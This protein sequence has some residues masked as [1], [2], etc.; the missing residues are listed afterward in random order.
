MRSKSTSTMD[1]KIDK[2]ELH[3]GLEELMLKKQR[4][5]KGRRWQYCMRV[6]FQ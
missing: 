1:A 5:D 3:K 2:V 6:T 4:G